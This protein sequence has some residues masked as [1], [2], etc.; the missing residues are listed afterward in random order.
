MSPPSSLMRLERTFDTLLHGYDIEAAVRVRS[1]TA[2]G[3]P[4]RPGAPNRRA[5]LRAMPVEID[6]EHVARLARIEPSDEERERLPG[7]LRVILEAA[8]K[9][10]EVAT[11]DVVPTSYAIP[12][13]NVLRPDEV[14]PSLPH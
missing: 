9:V 14:E 12:R 1:I 3:C 2:S 4:L 6:I 8:A 13:S 10:G 11:D 7:Q 5:T